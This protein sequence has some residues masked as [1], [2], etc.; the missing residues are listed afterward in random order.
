VGP[1]EAVG[2]FVLLTFH[3]TLLCRRQGGNALCHGPL[4]AEDRG[5]VLHFRQDETGG[6]R[7]ALPAAAD[8]LADLISGPGLYPGTVSLRRNARY[9][10]AEPDGEVSIQS[11]RCLKWESFLPLDADAAT[12]LRHILGSSWLLPGDGLVTPAA[13]RLSAGFS[14]GFGRVDVNL[15]HK[16]P[17]MDGERLILTPRQP[18]LEPIIARRA[19]SAARSV[20]SPTIHLF[21]RGNTANRALQYLTAESM[22]TEFPEAVIENLQLPEWGRLQV[23]PPPPLARAARTGQTQFR[24]DIPGLA[25]CLRR[26]V[27]DTVIID[28][29]TFN[30]DQYPPRAEAKRLLGETPEGAEAHGFGARELVCNVRGGEILQGVHPNYLPLP[31][32]YYRM[33]AEQSGLDLVF[34]GQLGEDAY[35]HSLREAFPKARFVAGRSPG[36]DFD[37]LRRSVHIAPAI[38]TFSWLAAW[39]SEAETIYLPL[40]GMFNP[41][42]AVDLMFLPL[43]APEYRYVLLPYQ[44]M[45]DISRDPER[46]ARQQARLAQQA[47]HIETADAREIARRAEPLGLGRAMVGGFD[48]DY[49]ITRYADAARAVRAGRSALDHYLHHPG[50]ERRVPLNFD[51]AFYIDCYPDAAMEIASGLYASPLRH[52]MAVGWRRGYAPAPPV[53]AEG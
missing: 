50:R 16:L 29:F 21:P 48:P 38:S 32:G 5:L 6:L 25:D 53:R 51:P 44:K 49:Y 26:R 4:P 27:V 12:L 18:G 30:I 40:G 11:Q 8:A 37:T 34:F 43:D 19:R 47:R 42:Q 28:G 23:Q 10:S 9:A 3:G 22:R 33:L 20:G 46:F 36:Y 35:S 7:V 45:F 15:L 31:P 2:D 24:I 39:L 41:I 14:L 13:I 17:Y 52:F 1:T